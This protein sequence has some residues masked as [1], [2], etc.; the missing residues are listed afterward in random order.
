LGEKKPYVKPSI[1]SRAI[2]AKDLEA[3]ARFAERRATP[4]YALIATADIVEPI[5]KMRL[6]GR[7]AEFGLGGCYVDTLNTLPKGA[8]IK[9]SIERNGSTL[10]IWGRVVYAHENIGMGVQFFDVSP[11]QQV[12]LK[13]WIAE[14]SSSEWTR[15]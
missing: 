5:S 3:G 15:L 13:Q 9:L 4:R 8:V 12:L 10:K 2:E 6:S 11:Q 7:T 1:A 14:L